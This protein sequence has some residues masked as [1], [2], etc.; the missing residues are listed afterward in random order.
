MDSP[1]YVNSTTQCVYSVFQTSSLTSTI[2]CLETILAF[3]IHK[4]PTL[5][6][7]M[8]P[9][10]TQLLLYGPTC[11]DVSILTY[12]GLIWITG[13]DIILPQPPSTVPTRLHNEFATI[14]TLHTNF[15][16]GFNTA[17]SM[18]VYILV[19]DHRALLPLHTS[20]VCTAYIF[21]RLCQYNNA[22]RK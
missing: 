20:A 21:T 9:Q 6:T 22:N 17:C 14:F 11:S 18:D 2:S 10:T 4:Y 7:C 1:M 13:T 8:R 3:R 12:H 19:N 15:M 5:H 16:H